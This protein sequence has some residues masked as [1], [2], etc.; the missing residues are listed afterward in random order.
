MTNL[1]LTLKALSPR[2]PSQEYCDRV[3]AQRPSAPRPRAKRRLWILVPAAAAAVVLLA[4]GAGHVVRW[5][6]PPSGAPQEKGI[7]VAVKEL[8][9]QEPGVESIVADVAGDW[10][11]SP[12]VF[13]E[14][15]CPATGLNGRL[16]QRGYIDRKGAWVIKP[17]FL[18][19]GKFSQG[20]AEVQEGTWQQHETYYIDR[21]GRRA[22]PNRIARHR[23]GLEVFKRGAKYGYRGPAIGEVVIEPKWDE[24]AP[25]SEGVA[26]VKLF[27]TGGTRYIDMT[28]RAVIPPNNF[29]GR[30]FHNGLAVAARR[31]S[32]T[33][34]FIDHGGKFVI[35]PT[36]SEACGFSEGLARVQ[37]DGKWGFIDIAGK[38]VVPLTY[39]EVGPFSEGLAAFRVSPGPN[40]GRLEDSKG[41]W[42]YIDR[43]GRIAIP[44]QF[45]AAAPFSEGL[46]CVKKA[47]G[48]LSFIDPAGKERFRHP[49]A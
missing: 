17:K 44:A 41:D 36:F 5:W 49:G 10:S 35:E 6:R 46:A 40:H 1:E 8:D 14:G 42:G 34:G 29:T 23:A 24:A 37:M 2:K 31:G 3:L 48:P 39:K 25:F 30:S 27:N 32:G 22:P 15:L 13:S 21:T 12:Y 16:Y 11:I 47:D 20:I 38:V 18:L 9:P 33:W 43:T 7:H 45:R 28:G 19:A 26:C 4:V